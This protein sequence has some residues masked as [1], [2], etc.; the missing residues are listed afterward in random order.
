MNAPLFLL[1]LFIPQVHAFA[2]TQ[3]ANVEATVKKGMLRLTGAV[4]GGIIGASLNCLLLPSWANLIAVVLI[5]A[6]IVWII[7]AP[8]FTKYAPLD[9]PI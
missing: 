1:D 4:C 8:P 6:T 3:Q 9:T 7:P 5:E 2:I